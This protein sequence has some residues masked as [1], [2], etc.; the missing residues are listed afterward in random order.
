MGA[1]HLLRPQA[2]RPVKPILK[3]RPPP[4]TNMFASV[5]AA[6]SREFES[7]VENVRGVEREEDT[8]SCATRDAA[9]K[10]SHPRRSVR[11][12]PA[13]FKP[14]PYAR[15]S[16]KRAIAPLPTKRKVPGAFFSS[17]ASSIAP[18]PQASRYQPQSEYQFNPRLESVAESSHSGGEESRS[19]D[20]EAAEEEEGDEQE[21]IQD[22]SEQARHVRFASNVPSPV[23]RRPVRSSLKIS[24]SGATPAPKKSKQQSTESDM[25]KGKGKASADQIALWEREAEER[26]W[27]RGVGG[28]STIA[29]LEEELM[30]A[31]SRLEAAR[32]EAQLQDDDDYSGE[33]EGEVDESF[34]VVLHP[35][36]GTAQSLPGVDDSMRRYQRRAQ[37]GS[38]V[39]D[40][41]V[42]RKR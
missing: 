5:F 42:P 27:G 18:T 36:G 6:V 1:D 22:D 2:S 16:P 38:V 25:G 20:E 39:D 7:F 9:E 19:Q 31:E 15:P 12:S 11:R 17:P 13:R 3:P 4:K 21:E 14:K 29:T 8:S 23:V 41:P 37:L 24:T 10:P 32:A 26:A 28:S 33:G 40:T 34:Q 35:R 30:G